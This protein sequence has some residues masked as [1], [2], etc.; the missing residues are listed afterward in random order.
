M[1]A[2]Q[3]SKSIFTFAAC[4][5]DDFAS[6]PATQVKPYDKSLEEMTLS[7]LL[8]KP[9][10]SSAAVKVAAAAAA[11]AA[12]PPHA[13]AQPSVR[14][15]QSQN[16]FDPQNL[17]KATITFKNQSSAHKVFETRPS[18][19]DLLKQYNRQHFF[20]ES[21]VQSSVPSSPDNGGFRSDRVELIRFAQ[22]PGKI[23]R[24]LKNDNNND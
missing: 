7:K 24:P 3:K 14:Y 15:R 2:E 19:N 13:P 16:P 21:P 5:L 4:L 11:A 12:V 6:T 10:P 8:K 18:F 22:I 9:A 17:K 20:G 23:I 1:S